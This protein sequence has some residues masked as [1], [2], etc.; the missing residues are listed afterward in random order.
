MRGNIK[1]TK[2]QIETETSRKINFFASAAVLSYN[3]GTIINTI[4]LFQIL[5]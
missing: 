4:S 5:F 1:A 2:T 3:V